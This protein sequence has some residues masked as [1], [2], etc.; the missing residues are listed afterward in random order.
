MLFGHTTRSHA[1]ACVEDVLQAV[2]S[3]GFA[4]APELTISAGRA[5]LDEGRTPHDTELN[6]FSEM[7]EKRRHLFRAA[8]LRMIN[9]ADSFRRL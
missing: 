1:A 2:Q 9:G 3:A 4:D 8:Q 6:S 7:S 5:A